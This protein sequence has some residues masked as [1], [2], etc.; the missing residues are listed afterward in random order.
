M[1]V[2]LLAQLSSALDKN[3]FQNMEDTSQ[4]NYDLSIVEGINKWQGEDGSDEPGT[5]SLHIRQWPSIC[6]IGY[7]VYRMH[8]LI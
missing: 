3:R 1:S 7:M 6:S 8:L 4:Q 2:S 5:S